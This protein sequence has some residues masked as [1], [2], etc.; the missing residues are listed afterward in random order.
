MPPATNRRSN[1]G[2]VTV[3]I[4]PEH[5][6]VSPAALPGAVEARLVR[7]A[8]SIGRQYLLTIQIAD[9]TFKAKVGPALGARLTP[10]PVWV[11]LP[12]ERVTLFDEQG[13]RLAARL[14]TGASV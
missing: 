8:V 3:G 14:A 9:R 12:P 4:R 6:Q 1:G 7:K 5:I 13:H 10:G 11:R 2:R